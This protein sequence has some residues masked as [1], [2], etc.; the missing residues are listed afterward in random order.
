MNYF[1]RTR[2]SFLSILL[3]LLL[4]TSNTLTAAPTRCPSQYLNGRRPVILNV[5]LSTGSRELCFDNFSVMHS[6]ISRT[7][8]WSAEH[9]TRSGIYDARQLERHN[10]FHHEEQLPPDD[11]ADL[12]DYARSGF[13]RGHMAPSADMPTEEAQHQSFTLANMVPQNPDN[14]RHLWEGIE[15]AVRNLAIN[16]GELYIIS[17]PLFIGN[18]LKRLKGRVLVPSHLYKIVFD[19]A[20]NIGAAYF[21]KNESG[22][23]WQVMSISELEKIAGIDFFPG[24]SNSVK[25]KK[26]RLPAPRVHQNF[27]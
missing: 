22:D 25:Q 20:K 17:G 16:K 4:G 9:L 5:K 27:N 18:N 26:L 19:P 10:V 11:R 24:L 23:E 7:P 14:N 3:L 1:A 2:L 15:S 6:A 8:L 21:V 13:D 12:N